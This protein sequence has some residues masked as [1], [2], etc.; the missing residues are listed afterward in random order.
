MPMIRKQ[1]YIEERQ[2]AALKHLAARRGVTEAE[3]VREAIDRAE[4]LAEPAHRPDPTA[5]TEFEAFVRRLR[6]RAVAPPA[7]RRWTRDELYAER[8]GG[9]RRAD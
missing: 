8:T 9:R 2:E 7:A 4:A 3:V 6:R 5:W 1:L